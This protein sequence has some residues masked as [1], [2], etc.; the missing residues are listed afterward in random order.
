MW[1]LLCHTKATGSVGFF[2]PISLLCFLLGRGE[3]VLGGARKRGCAFCAMDFVL[4]HLTSPG[5]ALHLTLP[6]PNQLRLTQEKSPLCPCREITA[7]PLDDPSTAFGDNVE[8]Q[9]MQSPCLREFTLQTGQEKWWDWTNSVSEGWG[10]S[11]ARRIWQEIYALARQ[12]RTQIRLRNGN[13]LP[14]AGFLWT[15]SSFRHHL[16]SL[17][18]LTSA[19]L[20]GPLGLIFRLRD[21]RAIQLFI[22]NIVQCIFDWLLNVR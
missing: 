20:W 21:W 19:N 11:T 6:T 2:P 12:H 18:V 8:L 3:A 22:Q 10:N 4:L 14:W 7:E 15:W 13:A 17:P 1:C 5:S 16:A 9:R